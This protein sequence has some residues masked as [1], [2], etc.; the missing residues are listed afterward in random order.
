[1]FGEIAWR[2]SERDAKAHSCNRVIARLLREPVTC[3]KS[4]QH[5]IVLGV[6]TLGKQDI[7]DDRSEKSYGNDRV[8]VNCQSPVS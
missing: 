6:E 8:V 4:L 5:G 2:Q 1:M 3:A 7:L